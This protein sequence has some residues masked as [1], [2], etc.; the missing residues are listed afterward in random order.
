[1][2]W[3]KATHDDFRVIETP[4]ITHVKDDCLVFRVTKSGWDT[5]LLV[6]ELA[7][8]LMISQKRIGYAG[9]KDTAATTTQWMS[10]KGVDRDQLESVHLPRVEISAIMEGDCI[11]IGELEGNRFEVV[12]R[13]VEWDVDHIETTL[14]EACARF[15]R[16][17]G[18]INYFGHQRFGIQRPI[19]AEVGRHIVKKDYE[20][21]A[22]TFLAEQCPGDPHADVR[23]ELWE[24]RDFAAAYEAFPH[25][26]KYERAMLFQLAHKGSSYLESFNALPERLQT[27]FVHAYQAELFNTIVERRTSEIPPNE[28]EVGDMIMI[29]KFE[30]KATTFVNASNIDKVRELLIQNVSL[31]APLI[32]SKTV[33][34]R[35]RMGEIAREVLTE[36]GISCPDFENRTHQPF[37]STGSTREVIGR[38]EDL[39]YTIDDDETSDGRKV[40]LTFFLPRGQYAT[41]LIRQMFGQEI[42]PYG[43]ESS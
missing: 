3:I 41:E 25:S 7:K 38:V 12:V 14:D 39:T 32:G 43:V 30:R 4:K 31:A 26:L 5:T 11:S 15:K 40:T 6:K 23:G 13:G 19:T 9:L 16:Y 33:F 36:E 21:A 24:S 8:R 2:M 35:S 20:R 18:F 1:M 37:S 17:N 10:V 42:L 27:L 22:L 34:S 29:D 28:V